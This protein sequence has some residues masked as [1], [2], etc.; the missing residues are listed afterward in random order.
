M[1]DDESP[2]GLH[3]SKEVDFKL[4]VLHTKKRKH[5]MIIIW[6]NFE[7]IFRNLLQTDVSPTGFH[8]LP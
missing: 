4:F 1:G 6:S 8:H 5:Y 3:Q 2:L 7:I